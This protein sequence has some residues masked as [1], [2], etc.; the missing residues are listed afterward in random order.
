MNLFLG[1]DYVIT[2]VKQRKA[3]PRERQSRIPKVP[4]DY[5]GSKSSPVH[6]PRSEVIKHLKSA[7]E[8]IKEKPTNW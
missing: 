7:K 3:R 6:V 4:K 8:L 1:N 5:N 2:R